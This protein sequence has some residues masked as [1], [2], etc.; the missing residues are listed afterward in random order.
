MGYGVQ[1]PEQKRGLAWKPSHF[2]IGLEVWKQK[3]RTPHLKRI[4]TPQCSKQ[5]DSFWQTSVWSLLT[6]TLQVSSFNMFGWEHVPFQKPS[7]ASQVSTVGTWWLCL[8]GDR[9]N[10]ERQSICF[11]K[12]LLLQSGGAPYVLGKPQNSSVL[13]CWPCK[14]S[15][16]PAL[17]ANIYI[18]HPLSVLSS[19][20]LRSSLA[21]QYDITPSVVPLYRLPW[22][23]LFP[24]FSFHVL[25]D[26]YVHVSML[27]C[28]CMKRP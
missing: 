19:V 10:T 25:F 26:I 2:Q 23:I 27:A 7:I 3:T 1:P 21:S 13:P 22:F 12:W 9:F 15:P 4:Q 16:P 6:V 8:V 17:P 5:R 11:S 20:W 14:G 18:A 24:P 28:A